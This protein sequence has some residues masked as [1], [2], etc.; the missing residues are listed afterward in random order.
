MIKQIK[1]NKYKKFF[2]IVFSFEAGI[3]AI[4]GENG[5]CKSSLLYLIG[6]SF[7]GVST[8][9]NWINDK[10]AISVINAR[11]T[12]E[13]LEQVQPPLLRDSIQIFLEK[14][15]RTMISH[16]VRIPKQESMWRDTELLKTEIVDYGK[17]AKPFYNTKT[18]AV[19]WLFM[20]CPGMIIPIQTCFRKLNS[21]SKRFSTI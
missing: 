4:S 2:D 17:K 15:L 14:S 18:R 9:C 13:Y 7:Q 21:V 20:H 10:K 6:N 1:I 12:L 11:T 19:W 8:S 16:W 3:N 5:T